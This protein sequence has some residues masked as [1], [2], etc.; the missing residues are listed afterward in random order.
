MYQRELFFRVNSIYVD[1]FCEHAAIGI[2]PICN[3]KHSFKICF[4]RKVD[5]GIIAIFRNAYENEW[6]T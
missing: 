4:H 5:V 1:T 6:C 3:L 2:H